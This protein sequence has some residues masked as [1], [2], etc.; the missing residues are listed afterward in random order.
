MAPAKHFIILNP[1]AGRGAAART[2][3]QVERWLRAQHLLYDLALTE[4]PGHALELAEHAAAVGYDVVVAAGGDGTANEVLNGL[5]RGRPAGDASGPALG[6]LCAGRGNDLAFGIGAPIG[7]EAGCAALAQGRRRLI[8]VGRAVGGLYPEGRFFGNGVGIGFDAVV[9]FE[10][11]KL[12]RLSG[13]AGYAVA[14]VRTIAVFDR[15]PEV[16]LD[17]DGVV[18]RQPALL[19]SAMNGRRM[20][21]GF[22][23]GPQA[24][25][26]DGWLD[27]CIGG[28]V[29]RLGILSLIG[30]FMRGSQGR[31][32]AVRMARARRV[33]VTALSGVLPAHADG[34]TL[35]TA[36]QTLTLE[37]RPR[38]LAVI[39][40]PDAAHA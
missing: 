36:G 12:K 34:E 2:R 27:L 14:A 35:C 37:L 22:L 18:T 9:G 8:D 5:L 29:S 28:Q 6:L 40:G 21:G 31:H 20:G 15:A 39:V 4:R 17:L 38:Q 33:R 13:F 19:V 26:E 7:L 16:E 3:P 32:P 24:S 30:R 10:A 11:L 23:M 25:P 1:A